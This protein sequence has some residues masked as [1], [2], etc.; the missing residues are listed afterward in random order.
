MR[1]VRSVRRTHPSPLPN[2][3]PGLSARSHRPARS[4]GPRSPARG[5][6]ERTR[7]RSGRGARVVTAA[8]SAMR[9]L[10][11]PFRARSK[12]GSVHSGVKTR[13]TSDRAGSNDGR[14]FVTRWRVSRWHIAA[15]V[16]A[17][18]P[19]VDL[20]VTWPATSSRT[21]GSRPAPQRAH[22]PR[23]AWPQVSP[24][25]SPRISGVNSGPTCGDGF[26][27]GGFEAS[28]AATK[29]EQEFRRPRAAPTMIRRPGLPRRPAGPADSGR[30]RRFAAPA[31]R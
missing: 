3:P 28:T 25:N 4:A 27:C 26:P 8:A 1:I 30:T 22:G 16:I 6:R 29:E 19:G 11:R 23:R 24:V 10:R 13:D 14:A 21:R 20:P 18:R 9:R 5:R 2:A 17:R 15:T 12:R 31:E 7:R